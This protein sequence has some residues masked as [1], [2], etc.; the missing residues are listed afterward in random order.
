M[1]AKSKEQPAARQAAGNKRS[2]S[3]RAKTSK[4][5]SG[6]GRVAGKSGSPVSA[7]RTT[8]KGKVQAPTKAPAGARAK[9]VAKGKAVAKAKAPARKAVPAV[10]PAAKAIAGKAAKSAVV[11][12]ASSRTSRA[13]GGAERSQAAKEVSAK[14]PPDAARAAASPRRGKEKEKAVVKSPFSHTDHASVFKG[15]EARKAAARAKQARLSKGQSKPKKS[16]AR[17]LNDKQLGDFEQMLMR[18]KAELLRQIA[19]LRG[20]S[21]TRSD[22]VNPEEDGTDAFERQLALK[23]AAG[24]GDSIFEIDEALGRIRQASYGVCEECGCI[25]P[26]PRLKAL[27]FA[28][29]CVEC[30]SLVEKNPG[31]SEHRYF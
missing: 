31:V 12:K 9:V 5:A 21:L 10:K 15:V 13:P 3:G 30:Q 18:I 19:Y 24:E 23:L 28:R 7:V 8:A 20:A 11:A 26:M 4:A 29:R 14:Q 22:E 25:I 2:A 17:R 1:A 27:P 16:T 6:S